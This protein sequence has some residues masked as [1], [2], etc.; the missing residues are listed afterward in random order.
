MFM[1]RMLALMLLALLIGW[2]APM[3]LVGWSLASAKMQHVLG[4]VSAPLTLDG[5]SYIT[6]DHVNVT[7][8]AVIHMDFSDIRRNQ[9]TVFMRGYMVSLIGAF[10]AEAWNKGN[11]A[12]M[13]SRWL[14]IGG[15]GALVH[16]VVIQKIYF[17]NE[18]VP[19]NFRLTSLKYERLKAR[20]Q[21]LL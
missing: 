16:K 20:L 18:Y 3:A 21:Q 2:G 14:K 7:V 1:K 8:D 19:N 11:H 6:R 15:G 10:S 5:G 9:A 13:V 12:D 4:P 17:D